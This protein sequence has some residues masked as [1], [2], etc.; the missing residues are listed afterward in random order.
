MI[1]S[2]RV[3]GAHIRYEAHHIVLLFEHRP[4]AGRPR[5][6]LPTR[7]AAGP[8]KSLLGRSFALAFQLDGKIRL[9]LHAFGIVRACKCAASRLRE[10]RIVRVNLERA[11]LREDGV[12]AHAG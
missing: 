6:K 3:A 2:V 8:P 7:S 12:V 5:G 4:R 1:G 9:R 11:C 10:R